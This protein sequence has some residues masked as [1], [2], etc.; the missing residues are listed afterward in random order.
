[1]EISLFTASNRP[2]IH[3]AEALFA[4]FARHHPSSQ[5]YLYAVDLTSEQIAS[6]QDR[7]IRIVEGGETQMTPAAITCR[8]ISMFRRVLEQCGESVVILLDADTI[9]RGSLEGFVS[10][11]TSSD[12]GLILRGGSDP[13]RQVYGG[14]CAARATP[15][16][17]KFL[18]VYDEFV[19]SRG[20]EWC[21]DQWA[22]HQA[23]LTMSDRSETSF[24]HLERRDVSRR[25][26]PRASI[27]SPSPTW[28]KSKRFQEIVANCRDEFLHDM[29]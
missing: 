2:F 19:A 17:L 7:G 24:G 4:S 20:D 14:I 21:G 23:Y 16:T 1:M 13:D 8:R 29:R 27:W 6:F 22:F 18:D 10:K 26:N 5:K 25:L 12:V 15:G 11:C 9:I 3:Y 28:R